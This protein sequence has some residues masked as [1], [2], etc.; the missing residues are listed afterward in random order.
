VDNRRIPPAGDGFYAAGTRQAQADLLAAVED[1]L[2][3]LYVR[4]AHML[5]K[6]LDHREARHRKALREATRRV[7]DAFGLR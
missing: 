1:T 2:D 4:R 5:P 6:L 3:W 7:R